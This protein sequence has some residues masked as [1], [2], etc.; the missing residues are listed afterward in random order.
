MVQGMTTYCAGFNFKPLTSVT[1]SDLIHITDRLGDVFGK[2]W[3]FEPEAIT[4]GGIIVKEWPGKT[5]SMYKSMRFR[6]GGIRKWS[7]PPVLDEHRMEWE[8]SNEIVWP[9]LSNRP[10]KD[11]CRTYIKAFDYAPPRSF[12]R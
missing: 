11:W 9:A 1:K 2:G 4:E 7:W 8:H 6:L 5:P 3:K 10:R 12:G